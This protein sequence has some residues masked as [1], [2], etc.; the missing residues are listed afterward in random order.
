MH[1]K[2]KFPLLVPF[3]VLAG[4][5]G[6][7]SGESQ[8]ESLVE[9]ADGTANVRV[10]DAPVCTNTVTELP[11]CWASSCEALETS[12]R[13]FAYGRS[14]VSFSNSG[15]VRHYLQTFE[16]SN[17][18]APATHTTE[19]FGGLTYKLSPRV[20]GEDEANVEGHVEFSLDESVANNLE[21][22]G[23]GGDI[24]TSTPYDITAEGLLCFDSNK[25]S[26]DETGYEISFGAPTIG[27]DYENCL[28]QMR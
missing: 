20:V 2:W 8:V 12:D 16:N 19:L 7:G 10:V 24:T 3:F 21:D 15:N 23:G 13:G 26:F 28:S 25:V 14:V 22:W 9:S 1:I 4:C 6:S 11:A 17:C 18:I 27:I 5:G